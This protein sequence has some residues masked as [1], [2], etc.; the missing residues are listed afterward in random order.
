MIVAIIPIPV[1]NP[2]FCTLLYPCLA[3]G[4]VADTVAW[5]QNLFWLLL[6]IMV[7]ALYWAFGAF[8]GKDDA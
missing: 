2:V 6:P 4:R 3:P 7:L 5:Q 8:D 1:P